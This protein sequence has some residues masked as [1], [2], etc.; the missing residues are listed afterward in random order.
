MVRVMG[1]GGVAP[2]QEGLF[3]DAGSGDVPEPVL[4]ALHAEYYELIWRGLKRH[5]FRRRFLEGR[6]TRWFVYL[7]APVSRLAAVIDLGPAVV[8][9]PQQIAAIAEQAR[10]G[11]GASV[12][13]YV[14][15][16]ERA[17]AI[18]I[19]HVAEYPGLSAAELRDE[20]GAFHPPQGYVRLNQHPRLLAICEKVSAE[21][22]IR[23]MSV[24]HR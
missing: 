12:L 20:L 5:E 4:M 13:E 15:D 17:F 9:A 19:L 22:P 23:R 18:P 3:G 16:L 24:H 11:N 8:D 1:I 14:Q 7:N 6:S 2:Q 10:T 21:T